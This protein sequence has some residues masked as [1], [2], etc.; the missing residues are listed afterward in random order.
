MAI[1]FDHQRNRVSSSTNIVTINST[2]GL[3]LPVGTTLARPTPAQGMVRYNTTDNR[4]EAYN[5]TVWTGLGGVV[6]AD[7]NTYIIA[8]TSSGANNNE[9]DFY[10]NG[11]KRLQIGSAG[12]LIFGGASLDKF[13]VAYA[14]GNTVV[15][16]TLTADG[17][18]TTTTTT[19]LTLDSGTTGAIDIGTSAN[20]KTITI[21]NSTGATALALNSGT[22]NIILTA[23]TGSVQLVATGANIITATTN[24]TERMRIDSSGNVGI[25]VTPTAKLDIAETWNNG[26]T[27]F[28]H[29]KS[30]VTDT[31]SNAASLLMNLQVG[32]SSKFSVNKEG[33][34]LVP[35]INPKTT[36]AIGDSTTGFGNYSGG[37]IDVAT[38]G[39]NRIRIRGGEFRLKSD[40]ILGFSSGD[41]TAAGADLTLHRDAANTF[42]Q[43]NGTNAQTLRIY[44]TFTDASNYER[45]IIAW[46]TNVL[47]IGTEAAGTG[48]RRQIKL[49]YTTTIDGGSRT[50]VAAL[51]ITNV[52]AGTGGLVI[53]VLNV[54]HA[55]DQTRIT[56]FD[57][58]N[59]ALGYSVRGS[60]I[61]GQGA[62]RFSGDAS[63]GTTAGATGS[64]VDILAP[65]TATNIFQC[66]Q[67]DGTVT[68]N[69]GYSG[70]MTIAN[71]VTQ[72]TEATTLATVTQTQVASFP[73]ASF[74]SAKLIIQAYNSVNGE[75]QISELLVAHNGVTAIATEYG[76]VFTGTSP[77]VIYEVDISAGN[78]RL[79]A[80]N[81]TA[82]STQYKISET[83]MVA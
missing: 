13:T 64:I 45:G 48:T 24:G 80:S 8:E 67:S 18:I 40:T 71:T 9:L 70:A 68:L 14:T 57:V 41:P 33:V 69:V 72:S 15:K 61:S 81:T 43:R 38:S 74:R 30:N 42:A 39:V 21:G 26:A 59:K 36:L 17:G 49:N 20:A 31:A 37:G 46:N 54:G 79:M 10:T 53:G 34:L 23:T 73:V 5:G 19:A 55:Q 27:T 1:N 2:G 32:G 65:S 51:T 76:I 50:N 25:G 62:H 3:T 66:R 28:T 22:G 44:N 47:D 11:V 56:A 6:D 60:V 75:V 63:T 52:G 78:V 4:F 83:L 82:N 77:F 29:I 7:Q 35:G 12:N 16:G 58:P